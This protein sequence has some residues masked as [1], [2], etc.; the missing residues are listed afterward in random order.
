M[1][2]ESSGLALALLVSRVLLWLIKQGS[3]VPVR[4]TVNIDGS[5]KFTTILKCGDGTGQHSGLP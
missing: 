1:P 2:F 4:S 5:L 3:V